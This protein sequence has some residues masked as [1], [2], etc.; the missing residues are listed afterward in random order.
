MYDVVIIRLG[1]RAGHV[2]EL[3]KY[4]GRICVLVAA[5]CLHRNLK[6]NSGIIHAGHDARHGTMKTRL[7]GNAVDD[8]TAKTGYS[9]CRNG[10]W[11]SVRS[12]C[13]NSA[14]MRTAQ[15]A[16]RD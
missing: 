11:W 8:E 5:R 2:P 16:S 6:A 15:T 4:R 1:Y 13:R 9:V 7:D 10:S 14:S 12:R 3:A